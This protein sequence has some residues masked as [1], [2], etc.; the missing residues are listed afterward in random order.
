M[1]RNY[2][3][4]RDDKLKVAA[5][6]VGGCLAIFFA[7]WGAFVLTTSFGIRWYVTAVS[8]VL[9]GYFF[10]TLFVSWLEGNATEA[11]VNMILKEIVEVRGEL[12]RL[13]SHD[14]LERTKSNSDSSAVS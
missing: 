4:D 8:L 7:V 2:K 14:V 13:R 9:I 5:I 10:L 12:L 11:A 3:L 6:I 1:D